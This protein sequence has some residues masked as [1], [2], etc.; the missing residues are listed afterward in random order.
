MPERGKLTLVKSM[1]SSLPTFLISP[2]CVLASVIDRNV[3]KNFLWDGRML[4]INIILSE[5][6]FMHI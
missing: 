3:D 1:F 5:E 4:G 2:L 6:I